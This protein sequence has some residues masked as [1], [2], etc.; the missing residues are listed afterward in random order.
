MDPVFNPIITND[1]AEFKQTALAVMES[2]YKGLDLA[3]GYQALNKVLNIKDSEQCKTNKLCSLAD[4]KNSFII[5]AGKEPGVK[6][7]LKMANSAVD[8]IDL[9]YY[10]GFR[11][12][13][14][15]GAKSP[16]RNSGLP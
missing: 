11:Q 16:R 10:E 1:S 5:E 7:P 13:R 3:P 14:S 15:P 4:G 6:G 2:H 8:A 9:Q 12:T